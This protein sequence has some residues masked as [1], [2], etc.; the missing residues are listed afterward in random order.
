VPLPGRYNLASPAA[1]VPLGVPQLLVHGGR[2]EIV[3]AAMSRA[4]A[5]STAAAGDR[6][7]LIIHEE[8][9]HFEHLDPRSE[10]WESVRS[11]LPG[12]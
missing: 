12:L 3:P 9:G 4:Y 11:W 6:I 2:D 1:R 10:A 8:L 7:E 5:R